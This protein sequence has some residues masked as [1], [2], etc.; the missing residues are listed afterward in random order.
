MS[1]AKNSFA[2]VDLVS[3]ANSQNLTQ[4]KDFKSL[5]QFVPLL[6]EQLKLQ[7][8]DGVVYMSLH[9][10][11]L[12][13]DFFNCDG[14]V[15][16]MCGNAA[17]CAF[18]WA[19]LKHN[20]SQQEQLFT[21]KGWLKGTV[22]SVHQTSQNCYTGEVSVVMT[23]L[24]SCNF[25][26]SLPYKKHN[27]SYDFI[28]SGVP[29][30]VIQLASFDQYPQ[31]KPMAKHL[32]HHTRFHPEGT[33]VTFFTPLT[34]NSISVISYERGVEDFTPACGTGGIAAAYSFSQQ[35]Q[36]DSTIT[37]HFPGGALKIQFN[38]QTPTM[39]GPVQIDEE[40]TF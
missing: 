20:F 10:N 36:S 14:S 29:H 32:R 33:N 18:V 11:H 31:Q 35:S 4:R 1:G 9:Q 12:K 30:V 34:E 27:L 40:L 28:N 37:T 39:T 26:Q 38:G 24:E 21:Q 16:E 13:W 7:N 23:E 15:A 19:H 5:S 25:R 3:P 8:I 2:F 17:R 6:L 22:N